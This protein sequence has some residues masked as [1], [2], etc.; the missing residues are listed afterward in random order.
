MYGLPYIC[1]K[2]TLH[3]MKPRFL[4]EHSFKRI[5]WLLLFPAIVLGVAVLH[6]DFE[7]NGFEIHAGEGFF[8]E[9]KPLNN[10]TGELAFVLVLAASF[11]VAFSKEKIEDE[12]VSRTRLESLQWSVYVNYALLL[13]ANLFLFDGNFFI[14]MVYN[15]FTILFFFIGRFNFVLYVL[16]AIRKGGDREK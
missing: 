14:I 16:P 12:W 5:G 10:L 13:F 11:M 4:L 9:G 15:M 6:F 1:V 7:I 8:M 2:Q 3:T